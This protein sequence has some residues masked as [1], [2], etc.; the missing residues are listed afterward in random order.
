MSKV[1]ASMSP[2]NVDATKPQDIIFSLFQNKQ[3]VF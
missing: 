1:T 3:T 2:Q